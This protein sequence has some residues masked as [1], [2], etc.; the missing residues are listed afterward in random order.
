MSESQSQMVVTRTCIDLQ[1]TDQKPPFLQCMQYD[2]NLRLLEVQ[3]K[4][5]GAD[6][7]VPEGWA[8]NL[9]MKKS[10]GTSVYQAATYEGSRVYLVL[11]GQMCCVA[12]EHHFV[13]EIVGED[14]VIQTPVL[15]LKVWKNPLPSREFTSQS[16]YQILRDMV[17]EAKDSMEEAEASAQSAAESASSLSDSAADAAGSATAAANSAAAAQTSA[18]QAQTKA[19]QTAAQFQSVSQLHQ[20][21]SQQLQQILSVDVNQNMLVLSQSA[22]LALTPPN[23]KRLY[24]VESDHPNNHLVGYF[25]FQEDLSNQ[26]DATMTATATGGGGIGSWDSTGKSYRTLPSAGTDMTLGDLVSLHSTGTIQLYDNGYI[27][28]ARA[29]GSSDSY[30]AVA[31]QNPSPFQA[32]VTYTFSMTSQDPTN[33][34][35]SACYGNAGRLALAKADG[36]QLF[37]GTAITSA[38]TGASGTLR[39]QAT[40]GVEEYTQLLFYYDDPA[41]VQ[42]ITLSISRTASPT[43]QE[44]YLTLPAS[45][46]AGKDFSN[47]IS[48]AVDLKPDSSIPGSS[49]F[50]FYAPSTQETAAGE[51][52]A[53]QGV[54][55]AAS[56]AGTAV[57][58]TGANTQCVSAGS[59]HTF[60]LTLSPTQ[61]SIYVDGTLQT[62]ASHTGAALS[63]LLSHLDGFTQNYLGY[64]RAQEQD[65]AGLLKNF[66]IY[67]KALSASEVAQI[68]TIPSARLYWG[69]LLLA[70][71]QEDA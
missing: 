45:L 68:S 61:L 44:N 37:L 49:I 47:G 5:N 69:S 65:Y 16:D 53:T 67:E 19:E 32:G 28:P 27:L 41:Y 43:T 18:E 7:P 55:A 56:W 31:L 34:T 10:D 46:F 48:V 24:L 22:Y 9:R 30:I 38:T 54:T 11:T 8:V 57:Q 63:G 21:I 12:G 29:E 3:L 2:T 52:Y 36:S 26:L 64:S 23:P 42:Y 58:Q 70:D 35:A 39:F 40:E 66:R 20:Q 50:Q 71:S 51:L 60:V 4:K 13:L 6:W 59:W 1:F 15:I 25:P 17:E 14:Q 62:S 33:Q